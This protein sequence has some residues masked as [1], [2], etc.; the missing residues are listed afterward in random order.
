VYPTLARSGIGANLVTQ[1][2]VAPLAGLP[3]P[4]VMRRM[5]AGRGPGAAQEFPMAYAPLHLHSGATV[6]S[7]AARRARPGAGL[8]ARALRTV[9]VWRSRIRDRA[10]LARMTELDL[11]DVGLSRSEA[12]YE[13]SKP[14][15]RE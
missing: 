10:D 5:P 15:W 11:R 8:L 14:F 9:Q 1:I 4:A 2:G 13:L 3:D 12:R 6:S 7:P